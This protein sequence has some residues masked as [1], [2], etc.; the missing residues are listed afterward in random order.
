MFSGGNRATASQFKTQEQ[1][2]SLR[3]YHQALTQL[4]GKICAEVGQS[5]EDRCLFE[6]RTAFDCVLR[7][8]VRKFGDIS[9]NEGA[10][11]HHIQ[12]MKA[13]LGHPAILDRRIHEL[14]SMPKS[15]V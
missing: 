11:A 15:F 7:H 12:S 10:C 1:S 4:T 9:D 6:A 3:P 13:A 8:K 5:G 2:F 14:N